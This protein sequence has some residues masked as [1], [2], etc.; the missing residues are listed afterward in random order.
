MCQYGILNDNVTADTIL[1]NNL[2]LINFMWYNVNVQMSISHNPKTQFGSYQFYVTQ[3]QCPNGDNISHLKVTNDTSE[4]FT[5]QLA[6][7]CPNIKKTHSSMPIWHR[8]NVK[9]ESDQ[10]PM[11]HLTNVNVSTWQMWELTE[12]K[13]FKTY[14]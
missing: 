8:A 12:S 5:W 7:I 2:I 13:T 10:M 11:W 6:Y 14:M 1:N 9:C 4:I 3:C